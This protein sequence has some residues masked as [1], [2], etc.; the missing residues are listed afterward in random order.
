MKTWFLPLRSSHSMRE[1]MKLTS[2]ACLYVLDTIF[3]FFMCI[4][5]SSP[6]T[7]PKG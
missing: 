1:G 6:Q 3:S 5:L 2:F 4:T 7:N